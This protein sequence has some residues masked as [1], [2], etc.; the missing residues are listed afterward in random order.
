VLSLEERAGDSPSPE[1]DAPAGV[2]RDLAVDD[3]VGE[4]EPAA[5][6][7]YAIDLIHDRVLVGDEVEYAV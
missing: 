5:W 2:F 3:D 1:I 7:K 6:A 4:L